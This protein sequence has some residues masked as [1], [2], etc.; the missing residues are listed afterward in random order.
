MKA[1]ADFFS[2]SIVALLFQNVV[3][4][5]GLGIGRLLKITETKSSILPYSI[6]VTGTMIFSSFFAWGAGFLPIPITLWRALEPLIYL[7]CVLAVLGIFVIIWKNNSKTKHLKFRGVVIPAAI[8]YT[9]LGTVLLG[10]RSDYSLVKFLGLAFGSGI[11]FTLAAIVVYYGKKH[12][13]QLDIPE[14][15]RGLPSQLIYI[16]ILS[17]AIYGFI[18]SSILL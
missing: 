9:V 1:I 18:G 14:A 10:A 4:S 12:L 6:F 7:L 3:F 17:L 13:E 2:V 5:R 8:N 11:G 15:F 16:G